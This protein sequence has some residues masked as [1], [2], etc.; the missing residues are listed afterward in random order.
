M[1]RTV[2]L[3][4]LIVG[5]VAV[6]G[7]AALIAPTSPGLTVTLVNESDVPLAGLALACGETTKSIPLL[8]PGASIDV[9]PYPSA[10]ENTLTLI[11]SRDRR[12]I[13]LGYFEGN[14]RGTVTVHLRGTGAGAL[15]GEVVADA[16]YP[17]TRFTSGLRWA[18]P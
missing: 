17:G 11:D 6:L 5:A 1:R 8:A 4:L 7:V 18:H 15:E 13:L 12:Y 9:R 14:P 2:G 3:L 16:S 10:G